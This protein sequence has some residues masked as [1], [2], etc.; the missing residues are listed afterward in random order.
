MFVMCGIQSPVPV[1]DRLSMTPLEG[2][3]GT[4]LRLTGE[5]DLCSM[6]ALRRAVAGLLPDTHEIY[7]Q[8]AGLEFIDVAAA[9]FLMTLTERPGHPE[10]I[11][12]YP[13]PV[14]I[15]LI[16]LLCPASLARL[17]VQD[18]ELR[19]PASWPGASSGFPGPTSCCGSTLRWR[20]G[21]TAGGQ[22]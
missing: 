12:L 17:R 21:T 18:T 19:R 16:R 13:P 3:T 1:P 6:P 15:R 5:A 14:L 20:E 11:L 9:R 10:V 22:A 2:R 8:L 4:G 7:L